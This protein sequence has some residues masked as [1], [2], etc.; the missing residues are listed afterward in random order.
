[1]SEKNAQS[2]RNE[3]EALL[4]RA[5]DDGYRFTVELDIS[6][7]GEAEK[8]DVEIETD[9]YFIGSSV[10]YAHVD[11]DLIHENEI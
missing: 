1:M 8:D 3:L 7:Y 2:Y 4:R 9:Y 6:V 10:D 5:E 11:T